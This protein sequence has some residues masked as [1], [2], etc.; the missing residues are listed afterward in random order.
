MPRRRCRGPAGAAQEHAVQPAG[1]ANRRPVGHGELVHGL[2][3]GHPVRHLH[4]HVHQ[5]LRRP[6]A[7]LEPEEGTGAAHPGHP[8]AANEHAAAD[9]PPSQ[10]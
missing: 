10:Q 9:A 1:A 7:Q 4:G 8:T 3:D 6:H 5:V 2:S